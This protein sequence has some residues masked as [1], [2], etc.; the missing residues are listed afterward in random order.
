MKAIHI[1]GILS[2]IFCV[3]VACNP[4]IESFAIEKELYAVHGIL[5]PKKEDQYIRI[6]KVFQTEGDALIYAAETDIGAKEFQ[7][8]LAGAGKIY[9]ADLI[10]NLPRNPGI[11][12][13]AQAL[14]HFSTAGPEALSPGNRYQLNIR[15]PNDPDFLISAWTEIPTEPQIT[16]PGGALF[17]PI[18]MLYTYN[19]MDFTK[20]VVVRFNGG[21]GKGFEI[22]LYAD[23]WDGNEIKTAQWGPT[24]IFQE[25]RGCKGDEENRKLC[26]KIAERVVPVSLLKFTNA[27]PGPVHFY[28]TVKV[29]N[30]EELLS[31]NVRLEVTGIDTFLTTF[32]NAET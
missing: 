27:A 32:L 6:S 20:E 22:R 21:S 11:F 4:E 31:K 30:Q 29:A 16:S 18:Q 13:P 9:P 14:Y 3:G 23:F 7:V 17:S 10:T 5:N 26:Y 24:R 25:P 8:S 28:D 15:K 2:I 12:F 1:I 19:S